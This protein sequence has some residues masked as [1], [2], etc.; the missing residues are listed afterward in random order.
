MIR[1]K[2]LTDFFQR[3]FFHKEQTVFGAWMLS[4]LLYA[5]IKLSIGKYNNYK[6]F[7]AVFTHAINGLPLY[8]EYPA[9]YFDLNYYGP[10]FALIIAP[11]S[12][13]PVWVGLPLW[14]LAN[15]AFLFYAILRLPLTQPQK[16]LIYWYA[17]CELMTAQGVQQF[18]ISVAACIIL[19]FVWIEEGKDFWAAGLIAGGTL[20]KIYPIVGLAFFFFSKHKV[21]FI[22][23]GLFWFILLAVV[24]LLYTPGPDYLWEQYRCWLEQIQAKNDLNLFAVSQNISL[25]GFVR[26]VSRIATYSDLWLIIPG[27]L[28]F[29]I[30]YLRINQFRHLRFR[31][32]MLAHVLVFVILFS[33]GSEASGYVILMTGVALWYINSP[34]PFRLY[35]KRLFYSTLIIVAVCT[36][37]LVPA[38]IRRTVISPYALKAFPCIFVWLT[39]CYEMIFLHFDQT[40]PA[41]E[42][43]TS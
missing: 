32:M 25:L 29:F 20:L 8:A 23:S 43:P 5:I 4:G 33:T 38:V 30:P 16:T 19:T 18:N 39:I 27:L 6:I 2:T 9:E 7:S 17:L 21:R 22:L 13:L 35:N 37:E 11:F 31:M 42:L 36:T 41:T 14:V 26:K 28:L 10:L 34:S 1:T 12:I 15:T 40:P 3:P 24:P